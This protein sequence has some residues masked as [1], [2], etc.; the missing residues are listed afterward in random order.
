VPSGRTLS[1]I[2][3]AA[4]LAALLIGAWLLWGSPDL[5]SRIDRDALEELVAEAGA[6]GPV[7]VIGLMTL[8]VVA[9]PIPSAPIAL[10]SGAAYGHTLGTIW[11]VLGAE[12]GA[13]VAFGL[14]RFLGHDAIRRWTGPGIDR[15]LAGSQNALTAIVLVSRLLPFVSFDAVSYAAGLSSLRFWRFALAT[16][17]GIVPA[18]FLLAHFGSV[19]AEGDAGPTTWIAAI[20]L[21]AMTAAPLIWAGWRGSRN[22]GKER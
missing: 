8:A 14:A 16:L 1:R 20:G 7:L 4:A 10:A 13:L 22:M 17:A 11:V 3:T 18:S 9:S 5:A 19:A 2:G 21:G 12:L 6:A 15:G